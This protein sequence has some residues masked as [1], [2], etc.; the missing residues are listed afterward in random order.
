[1]LEYSLSYKPEITKVDPSYDITFILIFVW[2]WTNKINGPHLYDTPS[3]QVITYFDEI[4]VLACFSHVSQCL[5]ISAI[6]LNKTGH[7]TLTQS[8]KWR[9]WEQVCLRLQWYLSTV[10]THWKTGMNTTKSPF[11][12]LLNTVTWLPWTCPY[13][14][15][16]FRSLAWDLCR[17][18]IISD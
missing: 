13:I 15:Q 16:F 9:L 10:S 18:I 1:M 3:S 14:W 4:G 2:L 5:R 17:V 7:Q 8:N 11:S 6:L 12:I